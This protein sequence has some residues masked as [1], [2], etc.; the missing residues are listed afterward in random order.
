MASATGIYAR[1]R[2]ELAAAAAP[3]AGDRTKASTSS[4]LGRLTADSL[5]RDAVTAGSSVAA[6]Q[7]GM[8]VC[9][10]TSSSSSDMSSTA[11]TTDLAA[12]PVS[13]LPVVADKQAEHRPGRGGMVVVEVVLK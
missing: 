10:S 8:L 5:E 4:Q 6:V 9:V 3:A 13:D 2:G 11:E 12:L 1:V 7:T